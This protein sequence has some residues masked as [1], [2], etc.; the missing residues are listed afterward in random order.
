LDFL[1]RFV[2]GFLL[3][4]PQDPYGPGVG[5]G[6]VQIQGPLIAERLNVSV[7]IGLRSR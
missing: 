6:Q 3:H 7:F 5:V 4:V 1:F 2:W